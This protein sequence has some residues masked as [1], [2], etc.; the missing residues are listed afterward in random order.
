MQCKAVQLELL[1]RRRPREVII[2]LITVFLFLSPF[3]LPRTSYNAPVNTAY[4]NP[5]QSTDW[6]RFAYVQYATT[7]DYLCNSV[8]IFE[9][10][11]RL[12]SKA[13]RLLMYPAYYP[14]DENSIQGQLLRKARDEYGVNLMPVQLHGRETEDETWAYS[15]T[16]LL[17]F[18]QTQYDRVLSLDS[19]AT[20]L[21]PMDELFLLPSSPVAMPRAYWFNTTDLRLSSQVML[22]QPSAFEFDRIMKSVDIAGPST[23][24][25]DIMNNLYKGNALILPH[26]PYDLLTGEFRREDHSLYMGNS[27]EQWDPSVVLEEAKYIHFSDW[28]ILKPW[29]QTSEE[30]IEAQQP[31]CNTNTTTGEEIC[32]ARN[33]WREFYSEFVKRRKV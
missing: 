14:V 11:T 10:L 31:T 24:D 22:V 1:V 29:F 7:T 2:L 18:N 4:S 17:A 33:L 30:T 16:K 13:E 26:R 21:Q 12:K 23:Y 5:I 28:P 3:S 9:A 20:L 32:R 8:M 19:D 25:M 27:L 15:Y 6:S